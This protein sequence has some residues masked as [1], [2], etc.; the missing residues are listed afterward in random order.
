MEIDCI[1]SKPWGFFFLCIRSIENTRTQAHWNY[2]S[3]GAWNKTGSH[4]CMGNLFNPLTKILMTANGQSHQSLY[5]ST[6]LL[7][8]KV[9]L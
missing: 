5:F 6:F 8:F 7:A 9:F 4:A 3:V 1:V 2:S